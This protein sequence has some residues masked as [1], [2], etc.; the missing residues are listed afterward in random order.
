MAWT[1]T[2][3][4]KNLY[5]AYDTAQLHIGALKRMIHARGGLPAFAH[6]DGLYRGITWSV[7]LLGLTIQSCIHL[8]FP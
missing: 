2:N 1:A 6:N 7:H 8:A 4:T 5:G 3:S